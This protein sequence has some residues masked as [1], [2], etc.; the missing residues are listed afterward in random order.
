MDRREARPTPG[1]R[2]EA[3]GADFLQLNP[4]DAPPG[5]LSDW[6][7]GHLRAAISDG[8][9]PL[10]TRLPATRTLAAELG[11]SRGVVTESYQRLTEDGHVTG[12]GRRGTIVAAPIGTT[13]PQP[14]AAAPQPTRPRGNQ[15][16]AGTATER[17]GLRA[18]RDIEGV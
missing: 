18:R 9:L 6:L 16:V 10:G 4:A 13:S 14:A 15:T 1:D 5:G 7:T 3:A 12:H 11:I 17:L 8:R 2:I